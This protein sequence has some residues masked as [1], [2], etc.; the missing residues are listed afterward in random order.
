MA[1]HLYSL[2]VCCEHQNYHDGVKMVSVLVFKAYCCV[3][4]SDVFTPLCCFVHV[5]SIHIFCVVMLCEVYISPVWSHVLHFICFM[6]G[7]LFDFMLCVAIFM[8]C[9][10]LCGNIPYVSS[11]NKWSWVC[12]VTYYAC[13]Y[14]LHSLFLMV[15]ILCGVTLY[16]ILRVHLKTAISQTAEEVLGYTTRK[17]KDWFDENN[18]EIQELLTHK[19]SAHQAHLA[20]PSFPEKKAAFRLVCSKLQRKLREIQNEWWTNLAKSTQMCADVGDYRG[21]YE[22]LKAVYGPMYQVR[23]PL[24]SADGLELLTDKTAILS[25][26]SEHFQALFNANWTVEDSV[27]LR[28]PQ[29]P[30]KAD[31]D[32]PPSFEETTK[33][34]EQIKCGKAAGVDGIPPEA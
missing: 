21:F 4:W 19:R 15:I 22:D 23:S 25:R 12:A 8:Y 1:I 5:T 33:A 11:H 32:N 24:C 28:I 16:I 26:W 30:V 10:V 18:Q 9:G 2:C 34:I 14:I 13:C 7:V 20:Q 17:N 29:Q 3:V 27:I 31:L 6:C